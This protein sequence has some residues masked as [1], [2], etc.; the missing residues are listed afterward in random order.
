MRRSGL[1]ALALVLALA[2]GTY[3]TVGLTFAGGSCGSKSK[4]CS[5]SKLTQSTDE[6]KAEFADAKGNKANTCTIGSKPG[7]CDA[8]AKKAGSSCCPSMKATKL[9]SAKAVSNGFVNVYAADEDGNHYAV[10]PIS[11][12]CFQV[13]ES[14]V[15]STLDGENY[16]WC[17]N[18]CE[19]E[20]KANKA[21]YSEK[22]KKMVAEEREKFS[23]IEEPAGTKM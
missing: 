10:C 12:K 7:T 14:S 11:G 15:K 4:A 2:L 16:Y 9:T 20:F 21:E 1:I 3:F 5:S 18:G 8:G 22:L 23:S 19:D 17:C 6:A 13:N